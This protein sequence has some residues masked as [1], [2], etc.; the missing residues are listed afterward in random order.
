MA[1]WDYAPLVS[2]NCRLSLLINYN[3]SPYTLGFIWSWGL[4]WPVRRPCTP[5]ATSAQAALAPHQ[6]TDQEE[7]AHTT[8]MAI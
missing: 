5:L 2:T 8:F 6:N 3:N 7:S 1:K 4:R